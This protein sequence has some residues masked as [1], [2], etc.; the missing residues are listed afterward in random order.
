MR[1]V[2]NHNFSEIPKINIPRSRFNR[3]HGYKTTFDGGY[4]IP[5]FVDEAL[6]GDTFNL[7]L[8]GFAR[9]S[10]PIYPIMDN[11]RM[12]TF[13][14]AVPMRLVWENWQKFCGEQIDPGDSIDYTIPVVSDLNNAANETI[15]D[16]FGLPT[17]VA[18][19]YEFSAL[20]LRAYNLI[21]NE[22]FRDE[23]LQ[24]SVTV[25]KGDGPERS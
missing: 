2:M 7:N 9:L 24:D 14:F 23:N 18:A 8:T 3:S 13:F 21:Y 15:F 16:Y 19:V 22:W 11:M 5:M 20:P 10:T 4:L 17:Q 25:N 6:P 12:D 1:S